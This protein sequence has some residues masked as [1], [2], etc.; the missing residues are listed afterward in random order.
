GQKF[1]SAGDFIRRWIP[2]LA[3]ADDVH[4]RV[5]RV[6]AAIRHLLDDHGVERAEA[7]RRYQRVGGK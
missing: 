7:L 5:A 2:E 4:L 6:R 1:D 3:G